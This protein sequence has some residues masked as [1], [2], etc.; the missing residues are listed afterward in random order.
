MQSSWP[1]GSLLYYIIHCE[2]EQLY[3]YLNHKPY[4]KLTGSQRTSE[5][6]GCVRFVSPGCIGYL[7]Y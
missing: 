2:I 4:L 3:R 1:L 5:D 7:C 6:E